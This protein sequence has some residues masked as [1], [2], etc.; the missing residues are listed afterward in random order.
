LH[1]FRLRLGKPFIC[2]DGSFLKSFQVIDYLQL[3]IGRGL[4]FRL[5]WLCV[6]FRGHFLK[7]LRRNGKLFLLD[8]ERLFELYLDG[9][10]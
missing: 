8:E 2:M 6:L 3:Q 1:G 7:N 9:G 4:L 10:I 5:S